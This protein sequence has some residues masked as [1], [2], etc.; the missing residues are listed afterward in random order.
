M[1]TFPLQT[2][3]YAKLITLVHKGFR[4]LQYVY[5]STKLLIINRNRF[6][7]V[8]CANMAEGKMIW[9]FRQHIETKR[10]EG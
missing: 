4:N 3:N 8:E 5:S 10:E 1:S 7:D 9:L 2:K 6:A